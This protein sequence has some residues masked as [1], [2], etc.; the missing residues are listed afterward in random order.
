MTAN[1]QPA[2]K[3]KVNPAKPISMIWLIPIVAVFIGSWMVFQNWKNQGPS[4][5]IEFKTAS[6]IEVGTTKIKSLDV[7]IGQVTK[8]VIKPGL[9]GV[10]V[11][12]RLSSPDYDDFLREN[13][14]FWVVS[15]QVTRA[16]I[17]GLHTLLSGPY[18]EL[19][20]GSG[21]IEQYH[22]EGLE[23]PPLTATGTPGLSVTLSSEHDFSFTSGDPIIYK[24]F[25]VGKIEDIYFNSDENKMYYNAFIEAPYHTLIRSNTRFWKMS[26]I[27]L[28][29]SADG[30]KVQAGTLETIV[31]G[32]VTFGLPTGEVFGE[33]IEGRGYFDI[34]PDE[35]AIL[36]ER[37]AYKVKYILLVEDSIRGIGV[38]APVEFRGVKIGQVIRTDLAS[39]QINNLLDKDSLIPILIQLEPGRMGLSDDEG[40]VDK[41]KQ[42]LALWVENGLKASLITGNLVTGSQLVE[43]EYFDQKA[44]ASLTR[45]HQYSVIP[46][47]PNKFSRVGIEIG[48]LVNK[49]NNLPI[50][51]VASETEAVLKETKRTLAKLQRLPL[52][53]MVNNADQMFMRTDK[54]VDKLTQSVMT[55]EQILANTND[56]NLPQTMNGTLRSVDAI[57]L[58]LKPLLLH[59]KNKPNGLIF[60]GQV[61]ES[62]EPKKGE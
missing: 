37:F 43:L 55:L 48:E 15:P 24:G 25:S 35:Q 41:L 12:A 57:L 19:Y 44:A 45:F 62:I 17:S 18:I 56:A 51:S 27:E 46:L 53:S 32:G 38:G 7:D 36:D 11:T 21:E 9:D 34:Y 8:V 50:G 52:E 39:N 6:G 22:F 5:T 16:G 30:L 31:R 40:G 58:D 49:L 47:V 28:E 29:V 42:D 20:P 10:I 23:T 33:E 3:A 2:T 14:A 61:G 13:T 26:G 59:L 60:S 4:I 54:M 1:S